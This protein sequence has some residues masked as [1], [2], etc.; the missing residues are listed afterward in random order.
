M[1]PQ[2][3][4]TQPPLRSRATPTRRAGQGDKSGAVRRGEEFDLAAV[5]GWLKQHV[6]GLQGTPRVTQ[7]TGGASN[8]TYR[9]EYDQ[10]ALVLRRPPAGKKAKGAHDM[11]REYHLQAALGPVFPLVPKVRALCVDPG[12]MGAD[13]YV[14]DPIN[15]TI[16]RRALPDAGALGP[17]GVR[18]LCLNVIDTLVAL[19]KVDPASVDRSHL[20]GG[21]GYTRRQVEGWN[22]RY[23]D[24]RT[25]NVPRGEPLMRWLSENA[26]SD[27]ALCVTH[28][29]FRFDNIVLDPTDITRVK[30]VLDWE[31]AA[32][33]NPLLDL[34][35]LLAYWTQ[36]DDDLFA[37]T[38]RQ[39]P[40]HLKGMLTRSEVVAYYCGK[41]DLGPID[42]TFYQVFGLFRLSV[43]VQ[44]IYARYARGE[45]QN[46][47]FRWWWVVVAYLHH[48]AEKLTQGGGSW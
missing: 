28:N 46:G 35:N 44:Q 43:I 45:T 5:D 4:P 29:D 24:A 11:R 3:V 42:V 1:H 23:R 19:H 8:W 10:R 32:L 14:M 17:L 9:L 37:R 48:R 20:G 25:W 21:A 36:A 26:P 6:P 33:G 22:A 18:T 40:T 12:V 34:G 27:E 39:Q 7:Y 41:M 15:G 16:A 30:G 38:I 13:F 47:A 31:L 2:N